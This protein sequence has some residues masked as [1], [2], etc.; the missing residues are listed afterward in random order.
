MQ[1]YL[2]HPGFV[3]FSFNHLNIKLEMAWQQRILESVL[4][5]VICMVGLVSHLLTFQDEY[6]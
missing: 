2:I 6:Q 3:A 5:A 4:L 1:N